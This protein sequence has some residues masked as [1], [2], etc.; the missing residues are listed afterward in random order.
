MDTLTRLKELWLGKNKITELKVCACSFR[1][2]EEIR[3]TGLY[4]QNLSSLQNLTLLSIQSNRLTSASLSHLSTLP[5]LTDLYLSHNALT[6][7]TQLA[8][9]TQ[10]RILDVSSNSIKSLSGLAPLTELEELWASNCQLDDFEEVKTELGGMK[11]LSTVYFE[12]N[13]LENKQ[14]VLYRNKVRLALPNI[15]QIDASKC[16]SLIFSA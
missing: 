6:T 1:T 12:G 11:E 13:P 14:R 2:S 10:L 3:L 7:L 16:F 15:R 5:N 4:S 9:S 8:T